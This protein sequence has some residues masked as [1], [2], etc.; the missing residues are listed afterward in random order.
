MKIIYVANVRLPTER[1]HG[2]QIVKM[3]EALGAAGANLEL[4]LPRRR[5]HLVDDLFAYYQ[6]K[7]NFRAV[8]LPSLDFNLWTRFGRVK[9]WLQSFSFGLAVWR[10]SFRTRQA[11]FYSRD[12][13]L[14]F[15]LTFFHRRVCFEDHQPPRAFRALYRIFLRRIPKK[16]IVPSQLAER[17]R[18]MEVDPRT[19]RVIPNGVDLT[20]MEQAPRDRHLWQSLGLG[21]ATVVLFVG[22]FYPWKGI[23]TLLDGAAK[24]PDAIRLVLIGALPEN[25]AAVLKY[26]TEHELTGV[27]ILDY[28][29]FRQTLT[30][31][32]SADILVL[33]N[34]AREERSA[35][36][37]TP[38]K[39]FAYLA[40]GVPMV[41][42]DLP[43]FAGYLE[44]GRNAVLCRPD[45][46]EDLAAKIVWLAARPAEG[47]RLAAAAAA[48]AKQ[49][50]WRERA[51]AVMAFLTQNYGN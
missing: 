9:F 21:E 51:K 26:V 49:F 28:L 12:L 30:Y 2:L 47:A 33:P 29:P 19:Y 27:T 46:A 44:H 32:K 35:K 24:L 36:Y 48:E 14:A 34:T 8:H 25:K 11:V 42:S 15:L 22:H 4:W 5:N 43:S 39:L 13:F 6:V 3:C 7:N 50:E 38:L 40:A 20:E 1:A 41:A 10:R 31:I 23:Y 16:I 45:D 17:Y 18:A 37:T